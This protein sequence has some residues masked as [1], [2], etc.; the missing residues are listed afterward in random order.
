MV[1]LRS[2]NSGEDLCAYSYVD[3]ADKAKSCL[4]MDYDEMQK[5]FTMIMSVYWL[6]LQS[7]PKFRARLEDR[8]QT[9]INDARELK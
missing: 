8:L 1:T 5:W 3:V 4:S 6:T 9:I 7:S 2:F